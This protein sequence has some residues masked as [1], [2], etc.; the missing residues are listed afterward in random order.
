MKR[1]ANLLL[2]L[3]L[4]ALLAACVPASGGVDEAISQRAEE[5]AGRLVAA[6]D[7]GDLTAFHA[8]MSEQMSAAFDQ[9]AFEDLSALFQ[10]RLGAYKSMKMTSIS[11]SEQY[12]VALFEMEYEKSPAVVM[13]LVLEPNEPYKLSGL[14]FDAPELH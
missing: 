11:L 10:T 7:A 13:R 6:I 4:V 3:A 8:D 12:Y 14:W 1:L 9:K 5:I 2:V